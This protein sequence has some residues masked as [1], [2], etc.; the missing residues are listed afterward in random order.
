[1]V[2]MN[3][4]FL[5]AND[6]P[7]IHLVDFWVTLLYHFKYNFSL[8]DSSAA[9]SSS[10]LFL[11]CNLLCLFLR[12]SLLSWVIFVAPLL[13]RPSTL[14]VDTRDRMERVVVVV[15]VVVVVLLVVFLLDDVADVVL[16]D[17]VVE[18]L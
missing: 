13:I 11:F 2:V 12:W 18:L 15:V 10:F 16:L 17:D 5:F 4:S 8:P 6:L 9:N 3:L 14:V 7:L 1:M